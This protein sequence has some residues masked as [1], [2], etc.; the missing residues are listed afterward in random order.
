MYANAEMGPRSK[1]PIIPACVLRLPGNV[2]GIGPVEQG[3]V[4]VGGAQYTD[5][6]VAFANIG[7]RKLHIA[8]CGAS[9]IHYRVAVAQN[10]L[11]RVRHQ[12]QI[13]LQQCIL[14]GMADKFVQCPGQRIAC[15]LHAANDQVIEEST[16]FTVGES[17]TIELRTKHLHGHRIARMASMIRS[18]PGAEFHQLHGRHKTS[19]PIFGEIRIV[20]QGQGIGQNHHILI[21]LGLNPEQVVHHAHR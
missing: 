2:K 14:I 9:Q 5:Q 11:Y 4:P 20:G 10:L 12:I 8:S 15:R 1:G 17:L 16:E 19:L 21:V 3:G 6:F 13:G 7:A 18:E